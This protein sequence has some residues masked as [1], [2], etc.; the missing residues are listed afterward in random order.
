MAIMTNN[1]RALFAVAAVAA[2]LFVVALISQ[3]PEHREKVT[4]V[5]SSTA[6]KAWHFRGGKTFYEIAKEKGTD[7]VTAHSYHNMYEK[8]FPA[9]R[10][11][12]IKMLEIGLGC[13]MVS[14]LNMLTPRMAMPRA[15]PD[16]VT[17]PTRET[18]APQPSACCVPVFAASHQYRR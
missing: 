18:A 1:P 16:T 3:H 2:V 13:D 8:Y 5:I 4:A 15:R 14:I 10:N 12:R 6:D 9:I 11:K 7:K 17:R